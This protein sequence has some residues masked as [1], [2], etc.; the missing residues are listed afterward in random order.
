MNGLGGLGLEPPILEDALD[1]HEKFV[2]LDLHKSSAPDLSLTCEGANRQW[3]VRA[4][5]EE[6][7]RQVTVQF[8]LFAERVEHCTQCSDELNHPLGSGIFT[9]ADTDQQAIAGTSSF[10]NDQR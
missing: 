8:G 2:D 9:V 4:E 10:R 7:R 3:Q 5:C 1:G 6:S